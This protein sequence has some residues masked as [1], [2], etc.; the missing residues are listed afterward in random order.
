M[1]NGLGIN[2]IHPPPDF[3][4][5][6]VVVSD[7]HGDWQIVDFRKAALGSMRGE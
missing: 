5:L 7:I 3:H 1:P 6:L 4:Q 2:Y